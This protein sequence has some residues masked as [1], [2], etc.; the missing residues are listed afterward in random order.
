MKGSVSCQ[1]FD[2]RGEKAPDAKTVGG[3]KNRSPIAVAIV[4]LHL[5]RYTVVYLPTPPAPS[6]P[7]PSSARF[8]RDGRAI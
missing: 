7:S 3:E 8:C 4:A 5:F 2:R 1:W 6:S